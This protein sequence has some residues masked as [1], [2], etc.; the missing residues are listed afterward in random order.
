MGNKR[1]KSRIDHRSSRFP[2]QYHC[3]FAVIKTLS[4]YAAEM[5]KGI[6]MTAD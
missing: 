1:S 5:G 4:G 6:M 3:F 2:P